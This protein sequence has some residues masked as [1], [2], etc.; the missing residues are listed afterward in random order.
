MWL[1][2]VERQ[3]LPT[4]TNMDL[5]GNM[6][7]KYSVSYRFSDKPERPREIE[8]WPGSV[9]EIL[10][11]LD[12]AGE[13]V[14]NGKSVC[15]NC[16]Q[17]GHVSKNCPEEKPESSDGPRVICSNCNEAGHRVRDCEFTFMVRGQ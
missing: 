4:F 13:V 16:K 17:V 14:N 15:H 7:K 2:A 8:G 1:I 12:D 9:D 3:I 6:G 5:Q 10:S 11:R